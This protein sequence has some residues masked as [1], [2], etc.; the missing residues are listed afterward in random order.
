MSKVERN[1]IIKI[2]ICAEAGAYVPKQCGV[3]TFTKDLRDAVCGGI[4]AH[5]PCVLAIDDK[6]NGYEYSEEGVQHIVAYRKRDYETAADLLNTNQTKITFVQHEYGN[7]G[8]DDG[9]YVLDL[10]RRLRM[11]IVSTLN[12]LLMK[13]TRDQA[14][15]IR[16]LAFYSDRFIVMSR[17]GKRILKDVYNVSKEKI[18]FIP[19]GIPD[20]PFVDPKNYKH[21]FGLKNRT[22]VLSFGLLTPGKVIEVA[23]RSIPAIVKKNPHVVYVVLGATDPHVYKTEGNSYEVIRERAQ[24]TRPVNHHHT[25]ISKLTCPLKVRKNGRDKNENSHPST[26]RKIV[27]A[28]RT[29]RRIRLV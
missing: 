5:R 28:L 10:M 26:S 4:G 13:P 9:R 22:V 8:G 17:L 6:P 16:E 24:K 20:F 27:S 25:S 7:Y 18:E 11:P 1:I 23:I 19:H 15:V 21:Q 12:T 14:A 3:A 29:Q 2:A